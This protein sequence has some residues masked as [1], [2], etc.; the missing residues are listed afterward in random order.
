MHFFYQYN[1]IHFFA[2]EFSEIFEKLYQLELENCSI[3][4]EI[5]LKMDGDNK[6]Y[7]SSKKFISGYNVDYIKNFSKIFLADIEF[8][9]VNI[10]EVKNLINKIDNVK[11]KEKLKKILKNKRFSLN[12]LKEKYFK[13][14]LIG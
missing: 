2:P 11:I 6:Y 1:Q 5:I 8:L 4:S 10:I 12:F 9:E 13:L 7:S 14:N 3:L